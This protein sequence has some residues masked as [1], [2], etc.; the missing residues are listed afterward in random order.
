MVSI[1][2]FL[3]SQ[4]F[5]A[6]AGLTSFCQPA[7]FWVC[8]VQRCGLGLVVFAWTRADMLLCS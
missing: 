5:A 8:T 2:M 3:I 4:G 7:G 6:D 1:A